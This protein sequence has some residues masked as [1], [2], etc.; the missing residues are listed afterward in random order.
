MAPDLSVAL[1]STPEDKRRAANFVFS[2]SIAV[3]KRD[4]P[5]KASETS[6]TSGQPG[7]KVEG[8]V[9]GQMEGQVEGQMRYDE[10]LLL[11]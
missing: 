2:P 8:Q 1:K 11:L 7:N 5:V 6:A 10:S 4:L 3:I 9:E